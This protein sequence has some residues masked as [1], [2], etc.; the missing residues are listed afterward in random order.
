MSDTNSTM[1][2]LAT[3][4]PDFSLLEPATGETRSISDY[5]GQI[6]YL[7]VFMCNHCPFVT[8]ILDHLIEVSKRYEAEGIKTIA[9]N[10]NDPVSYPQDSP[11]K[12]IEFVKEHNIPFP[13]LFDETQEVAKSFRAAC[14]PDF[15]LLDDDRELVYRGQ[16]D[17]SRPK[18]GIA[19]SG[20]HIRLGLDAMLRGNSIPENQQIASIG[21]NI[22][23]KEG[24]APDYFKS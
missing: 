10:S 5:P 24:N 6:G 22:K 12:M 2:P 15:F 23:W 4:C 16:F 7:I 18:S 19:V 21:C 17:S 20:D 8:H 11:E 9:I 3:I 13:Y 14:T 1:L